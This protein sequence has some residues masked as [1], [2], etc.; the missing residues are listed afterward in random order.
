MA[1]EC[2]LK[3]QNC[4]AKAAWQLDF[5]VNKW[6]KHTRQREK[7]RKGEREGKRGNGNGRETRTLAFSRCHL[8]VALHNM[9]SISS[10]NKILIHRTYCWKIAFLSATAT[11][12]TITRATT[13]MATAG[14]PSK[15]NRKALLTTTA[16]RKA[17]AT[18]A[19]AVATADVKPAE[20]GREV[21]GKQRSRGYVGVCECGST[22]R[23]TSNF[24]C[25]NL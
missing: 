2:I 23:R 1:W 5:K 12:T 6:A 9:F 24:W 22:E 13:T 4:N 16:A 17:T 3:C 18:A 8:Q 11:T 7:E 20:G 14:E 19:S 15:K 25:C 10:V 21:C